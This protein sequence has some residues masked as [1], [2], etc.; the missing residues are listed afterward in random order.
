MLDKLQW[1]WRPW[2]LRLQLSLASAL[3]ESMVYQL[4]D[5]R[6]TLFRYLSL[7]R[8]EAV[9]CTRIPENDPDELLVQ[10]RIQPVVYCNL[11]GGT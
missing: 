10:L 3:R 7:S 2:I 6:P 11:L 5:S 9:S 4:D 1:C 8:A